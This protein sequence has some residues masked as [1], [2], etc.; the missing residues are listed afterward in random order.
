MGLLLA[1]SRGVDWVNE[2]FGRVADWC[3]F[4]ACAI[5]A[6]NALSRYGLNISSNAWLEVQW[7]F[8]A[9]VV[10]LGASYT[11][12]RNEH[13]RVDLVYGALGDRGRLYVDIFGLIVFLLPS[14]ALL[15]WMTWPYFLDA[16]QRQE[17]SPAPGGLIRW[18]AKLLMPLG[19]FLLILQGLSELIKRIALLRG[20]M[21]G[22]EVVTEYHRPEQ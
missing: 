17:M 10:M 5:S 11:L 13:V 19:F 8:F 1:F 6:G 2:K 7:Y 4:L 16:L 18:P 21:D 20:S 22:A 15:G 14:M 3:V 12:F 9:A